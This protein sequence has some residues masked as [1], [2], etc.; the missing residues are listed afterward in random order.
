MPI[1]VPLQRRRRAG[2]T[3]YRSRKRAITSQEPLLVVRVSNKNVSSQFIRPKVAGDEVLLSVHSR[4]LVKLGW[5]GSPK[6][7]PAC[8]LLGLL[9]GKKALD[10]GIESAVIY[11]GVVPF[12]KGSRIA[13]FAKG[14]VDAGVKIPLGEEALPDEARLSGA[15]IADYASRLSKEDKDLY[16]KR[17][18]SLIKRGF[19]PEDYQASFAK[20]KANIVGGGSKQQ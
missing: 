13:A 12:V 11:N 16:Q 7:V 15:A 20:M 17:F 8:Y 4:Q 2:L 5:N 3:D 14:V 19:R 18:S 6:S 1:H 9:I 10:K